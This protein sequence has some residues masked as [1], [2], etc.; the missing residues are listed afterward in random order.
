MVPENC[1]GSILQPHTTNS[2]LEQQ[3]HIP[4]DMFSLDTGLDMEMKNRLDNKSLDYKD[5]PV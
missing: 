1:E 5:L 2:P 4:D 3:L